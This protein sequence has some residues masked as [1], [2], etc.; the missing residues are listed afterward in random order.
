MNPVSKTQQDSNLN[1]RLARLTRLSLLLCFVAILLSSF[2]GIS[3]Y[4]TSRRTYL[5]EIQTLNLNLARTIV[6]SAS[7]IEGLGEVEAVE[8]FEAVWDSIKPVFDDSYLCV[9]RRSGEMLLH[10]QN[11]AAVGRNVNNMRARGIE[12]DQIIP[13]GELANNGVDWVGQYFSDIDQKQVVAFAYC[14]QIDGMLGIHVPFSKASDTINRAAAPWAVGFSLVTFLLFPCSLWFLLSAARTSKTAY[15]TLLR[16]NLSLE[17]EKDK[18]IQKSHNLESIG[19]LAGGIAHDF[20]NLLTVTIGNLSMLTRKLGKNSRE[21]K[22]ASAA[23]ESSLKSKELTAQLMTFAK[24]G[25]PNKKTACVASLIRE[26]V[27]LNLHGSKTIAQYQFA[28]DLLPV[29]IDLG[30]MSQVI[31]N[32]VINA[33]QAMP[34]GGTLTISATNVELSG[35]DG[36]PTDLQQFVKIEIQDCGTGMSEETKRKIFDP[37][38]S[39]K[40]KGHGLGLSIS[41]RIISRHQGRIEVDSVQGIGTKFTIFLPGSNK[42]VSFEGQ[43]LDRGISFGQGRILLMDDEKSIHSTLSNMLKELGYEVDCV[44]DGVQMIK[45][46]GISK[47]KD[48]LYDLVILDLTI[49]GGMGGREAMERMNKLHPEATVIVST[50]YSNDPIMA[51]FKDYGFAAKLHKPMDLASL[52]VTVE[53]ALN[54]RHLE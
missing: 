27:D 18:E 40:D 3:A 25:D 51:N 15:R 42:Q 35:T 16:N 52:A 11:S 43:Q 22:W 44:F 23:S 14:E 33:D 7:I 41:Y 19:L 30:Q 8:H 36:S 24:G 39:T 37:Y 4:I 54:S 1:R 28:E 20:N 38:F 6:N 45:A 2:V 13:I 26:T 9:Y 5:S 50:G 31:Q 10:T 17:K 34:S 46:Y 29:D 48:K 47:E 32:L 49:P 12:N 53:T 21:Y